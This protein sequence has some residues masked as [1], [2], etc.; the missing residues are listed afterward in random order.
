MVKEK[1]N[2]HTYTDIHTY[3]HRYTCVYIYTYIYIYIYIHTDG[4]EY[5]Y[6]YIHTY[7]YIYMH[8]AACC[9]V[10]AGCLAA[11]YW[12]HD[13]DNSAWRPQA[14]PETHAI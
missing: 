5:I 3:R 4:C 6:I 11:G 7:I 9:W 10:A 12:L 8:P 1:K 14:S 13:A 2:I